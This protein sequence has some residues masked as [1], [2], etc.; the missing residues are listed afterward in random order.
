MSLPAIIW[1]SSTQVGNAHAKALLMHL[2]THNFNSHTFYF[3]NSTYAKV[4]EIS[5]RTVIRS[6]QLLEEKGLIKCDPRFDDNGRQISNSISLLI[7]DNFMNDYESRLRGEGDN[8]KVGDRESSLGVTESQGGGCQSG[9]PYNNNKNNNKFNNNK[10]SFYDRSKSEQQKQDNAQKHH[11]A[12]NAK[13]CEPITTDPVICL[14]CQRPDNYCWCGK[15]QERCSPQLAKS[16]AEIALMAASGKKINKS[17]LIA[18][19]AN[20]G[21][22]KGQLAEF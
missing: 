16:F 10:K 21:R 7:P 14:G 11:W 20:H 6:I 4:L 22:E 1:S 3:K 9:T 17:Q 8:S 13:V 15:P 12:N 19:I 18:G 5:E 2:A